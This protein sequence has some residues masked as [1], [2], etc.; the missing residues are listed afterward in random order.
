M[1]ITKRIICLANSRKHSGRCIAGKEVNNGEWIRPVSDREYEEVSE[2]ERRYENGSDPTLMDII[3][4]PLLKHQPIDYQRENWLLDP[5]SYWLKVCDAEADDLRK[6]VD[7]A[8][9]L[10]T[11]ESSSL[12][13]LND[14]IA[15]DDCKDIDDSLRFIYVRNLTLKVFAPGEEFGNYK[16]R[17]QGE[18]QYGDTNYKLMVTDPK[19]ERIYLAKPNGV[20]EVGECFLTVSLGE[21]FNN[22]AYKLIV[23]IIEC[24]KIR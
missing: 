8:E 2:L 13:G 23:A 15:E 7:I 9:S 18:F 16:R 21:L 14:R 12:Q 4:I 10:W 5:N 20:Y 1:S 6:L 17:V 24:K 19:I 11:N 22:F 3:D